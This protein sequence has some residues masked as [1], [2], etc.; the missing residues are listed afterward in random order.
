MSQSHLYPEG[1][2]AARGA[3]GG[4]P[5]STWSPDR[6]MNQGTSIEQLAAIN[7]HAPKAGPALKQLR[8]DCVLGYG[9]DSNEA[10]RKRAAWRQVIL[11]RARRAR[12][13][14]LSARAATPRGPGQDRWGE[15][16]AELILKAKQSA[17]QRVSAWSWMEGCYQEQAWLALHEAHAQII[18]LL[19][20]EELLARADSVLH[21][22]RRTLGAEDPRVQCIES[23]LCEKPPPENQL[24]PRLAHLARETFDVLD[25]KY[26]QSRGYRNRLIRL[27]SLAMAGIALPIIAGTMSELNFHLVHAPDAKGWRLVALIMLFGSVGALVTAIPPLAKANGVRNPF[28]LPFFQLL[29]KLAMGPLFAIVGVLILQSGLINGLNRADDVGGLLVWATLFGAAQ[30]SV[31][32]FIDKRV[33]GL[34]G[35]VPVAASSSKPATARPRGHVTGAS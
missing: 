19:P 29:L 32:H 21:K 35:E 4:Q 24:R 14:L 16:P 23:L 10:T 26:A 9:D 30:Q 13:E 11:S 2:D 17:L 22:A 33:T 15:E 5:L 20:A 3:S 34:L 1:P 12:H 25:D 28:S 18:E 8:D 31:T 6:T 7:G 27:T